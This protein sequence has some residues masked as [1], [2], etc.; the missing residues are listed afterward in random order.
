MLLTGRR[1]FTMVMSVDCTLLCAVENTNGVHFRAVWKNTAHVQGIMFF[2]RVLYFPIQ[3]SNEHR[4]H[5]I[6]YRPISLLSSLSKLLTSGFK[7][8]DSTVNHFLSLVQK[9]S[10]GLY[11]GENAWPN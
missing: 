2:G 10:S 11:N 9:L 7:Q 1:R 3:H 8:R 5:N 6:S 4:L